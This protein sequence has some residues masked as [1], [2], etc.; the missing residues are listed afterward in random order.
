MLCLGLTGRH[1]PLIDCAIQ[2]IMCTVCLK[3]KFP[4]RNRRLRP[5]NS[6]LRGYTR[7]NTRKMCTFCGFFYKSTA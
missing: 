7:F 4:S 5:G 6:I 2:Y 3:V 1:D